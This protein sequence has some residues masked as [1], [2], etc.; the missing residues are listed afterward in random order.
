MS[1]TS[2]TTASTQEKLL[3]ARAAAAKLALLSKEAKN[4][5]LLAIAEAIEAHE[6]QILEANRADL[7]DSR[8]D[9]AMSDRLLLT[10]ARIKDMDRAVRDVA[11]LPDPIGE[12]LAEWQ[13]PNG[14]VIR[15]VRVPLGVI[16]IIYESRPNVTVDT[17]V[18]ALKTGN[19][20]VLRGGKEAAQTNQRLVEIMNTI[21]DLPLGAIELVDSASRESVHELI[22]ARGLVDVIIPRG[23]PELIK[24]V[25]ENSVVPVI[26]TGA[27]N[28]HIFIDESADFD[29]ADRIVLNAKTQRPSVCN[30]VE[31]LLVHAAIAADYIS[32]IIQKLIAAGVEVRGDGK[33]CALAAGLSV[34][35]ATDQDWDEEYLRL[36]MAIAVV[37]DLDAAIAH[38]NKHSTKHSEAIITRDETHALRFLREVD[39]A[40]VYWNASTRFTDGGEF[41]FGAEMG[42]STQKLHCR[43][44]FALAELTSS[45]YEIIGTG[46]TR[47]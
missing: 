32:G 13:R 29:M 34:T 19:A 28:C 36:C 6:T 3:R 37:P 2:I 20:I 44:P 15:K 33:T 8:L 14:L 46:Q 4:A 25:A 40:A 38:I 11:A 12:M 26:E 42:I 22:K 16:G 31:K 10:S 41:G 35:P 24:F 23:G 5:I 27:G 18:L 21:P 9:G 47:P 43:G 30:A 45:K 17:A 1:A 39:S 7:Q